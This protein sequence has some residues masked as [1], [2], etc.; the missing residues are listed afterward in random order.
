MARPDARRALLSVSDKTGIVELARA[1]RQLGFELVSTGGTARAIA[2]AGLRR[3]RG[4]RTH[5]LSRDHGRSRENPAP[6]G[7]RRAARPDRH[8]RCSH[9]RARHR[10]DRRGRHQPLPVRRDDRETRTAA[11]RTRSRTSTSAARRC[12]APPPRTTRASPCSSI[13]RTTPRAL[14]ELRTAARCRGDAPAAR[15]KGL[16][17][18]PRSYDGLGFRLAAAA[19]GRHRLF[20]DAF[21][22]D[23]ARSRTCAMARTRTR[24]RRST[25]TRS[26]RARRSRR[27]GS[28]RARSFLTTTSRT[29]TPRIE[30]VRQFDAPACVIVK[31]AN[32]CGVAVAADAARGLPSGLRAG[33]DIGLRRNHRLQPAARCTKRPPPSSSA[34]SSRSSWPRLARLAPLRRSPAKQNIR[35]LETGLT[36]GSTVPAFEL[37]SVAGG[38]LVQSRDDG[39]G[40]KPRS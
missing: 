14:A 17:R 15:C 2:G 39:V 10:A 24:R 16:R 11:T 29:R 22:A 13:R 4:R 32:P 7:A 38:L 20:P 27:P 31:H 25:P 18:T 35:V 12:C 23:S 21:A 40:R 33:H 19:A 8:R 1:L 26:R 36:A 6:E 5:R 28:C 9:A 37:K 34:S 30:C 3:D